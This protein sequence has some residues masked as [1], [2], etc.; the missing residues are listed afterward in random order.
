MHRI[1]GFAA[2]AA[3]ALTGAASAAHAQDTSRTVVDGGVHV[4]GWT[5]RVDANEERRGGT[6]AGARLAGTPDSLHATTGPA[7]AYWHADN[8][9]SGDYTV[10]ATFREPKY[11]AL[12]D[13]PH[14]YGLFI[15]GSDMGSA[16]Q[17]Y[18]VLPQRPAGTEDLSEE[19][20]AALVTRDAMIGVAVVSATP[21]NPHAG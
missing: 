4:A 20:L 2:A 8:V 10:T 11:M 1:N 19:A 15:A 13:H 16:E 14:P 21:R 3:I 6:L 9:A 12:N 17:R 18:L 5:G 7:L